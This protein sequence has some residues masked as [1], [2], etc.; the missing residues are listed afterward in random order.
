MVV[1]LRGKILPLVRIHNSESPYIKMFSQITQVDSSYY[2]T[3]ISQ[4]L[5]LK[6]HS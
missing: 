6:S 5:H 3:Q 1:F 4:T 2:H